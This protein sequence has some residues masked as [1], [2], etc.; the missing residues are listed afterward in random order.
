MKLLFLITLALMMVMTVNCARK[1]K[2]QSTPEVSTSLREERPID[3]ATI[4][5]DKGEIQLSEA[6]QQEL[7]DL[8][9]KM[10]SGGKMISDIKI[11]TWSDRQVANENE[12][13]NTDIILA[14]QRAESIKEYIEKNLTAYEDIDFY[15]MAQRPADYSS[16]LKRQ[17]MNIDKAFE[18]KGA[19]MASNKASKGLV[20]IEYKSGPMPSTL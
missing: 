9:N 6:D 2:H 17:G 3:Y 10:R 1:T 4:Q 14:R 16:Y 11:L 15:N 19:A 13:S 20:I 18:E 8:S 7:D 5:F 12:A